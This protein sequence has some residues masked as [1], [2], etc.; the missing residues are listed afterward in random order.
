VNS[1]IVDDLARG[2]VFRLDNY[3]E[4][5]HINCGAGSEISIRGLA[6]CVAR[7]TGFSGQLVFD[8]TKPDGKPRKLMDS[9]RILALGWKPEIS[10]DD[11]VDGAYRWF[12]ENKLADTP[13]QNANVA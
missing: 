10:L 7:A 3:D 8:T 6:E 12:L 4:Y 13:R 2:G 5:E 9:S 11:G 1:H